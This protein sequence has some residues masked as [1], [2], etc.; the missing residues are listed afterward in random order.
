MSKNSKK[1]MFSL[2]SLFSPK[3]TSNLAKWEQKHLVELIS[4]VYLLLNLL[5]W[6]QKDE[7][8][9]QQGEYNLS[10][11]P[12]NI[13]VHSEGCPNIYTR[14]LMS[15][16][17][18]VLV[19]G[20]LPD[21]SLPPLRPLPLC[22]VGLHSLCPLLLCSS[23]FHMIEKCYMLKSKLKIWIMPNYEHDFIKI[24]QHKLYS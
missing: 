19:W 3:K 18:K 23:K 9:K 14:L 21:S 20:R 22:H 10:K 6:T 13:G 2:F 24:G 17:I 11:T 5:G 15:S 8:S 12:F 7:G 16:D 4:F 1:I